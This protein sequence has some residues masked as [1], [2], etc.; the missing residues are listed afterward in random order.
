MQCC[1]C[2][3]LKFLAIMNCGVCG[4]SSR[5]SYVCCSGLC[6]RRFHAECVK[7]PIDVVNCLTS[8]KGLHWKCAN[9]DSGI[10]DKLQEIVSTQCSTLLKNMSEKLD[11][12]SENIVQ[13]VSKCEAKISESS[14]CVDNA[15]LNS[16]YASALKRPSRVIIRPKNSDQLSNSTKADIL[17][18]IDLVNNDIELNSVKHIANGGILLGCGSDSDATKFRQIAGD[19]LTDDYDIFELRGTDL[20]I[21]IVGLS[22]SMGTNE[23]EDLLR[24]QNQFIFQS[25]SLLKVLRVFPTKKNSEIHQATLQVCPATFKKCIDRGRLIVG[26]DSCVVFD[27]I[28]IPR[29]YTCNSFNHVSK[30]CKNQA[31]CPLCAGSHGVK[32]CPVSK[33]ENFVPKCSNCD[34]YNSKHQNRVNIHHAAW[35]Y[36]KC[37]V[38]KRYLDQAR[39]EIF[40][41][42]SIK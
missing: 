30:Y 6:K 31:V 5:K 2:H 18:N 11:I 29:C 27:A 34:F 7:I 4:T 40:G 35:D 41:N 19:K 10:E 17:E 36:K 22:Q 38:Y 13:T 1:R 15:N 39:K 8:I 25:A 28:N 32:T 21:R 37:E 12:M 9:C 26:L 14:N 20:Q 3:A 33:K 24:K 23:L 16:S 42:K